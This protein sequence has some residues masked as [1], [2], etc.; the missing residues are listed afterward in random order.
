MY[1]YSPATGETRTLVEDGALA[2]Y[3]IGEEEG[4]VLFTA[5]DLKQYGSA[6]GQDF[7]S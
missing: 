6:S 2:I 4:T 7:T 3:H 5:S 1:A